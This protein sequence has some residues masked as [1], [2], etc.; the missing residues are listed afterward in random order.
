MAKGT[1]TNK[2]TNMPTLGAPLLLLATLWGAVGS[3]LSAFT[4]INDRRDKIIA[5]IEE[6]GRCSDKLL[7]PLELYLTN[8]LPLSLGVCLFLLIVA[9]IVVQIPSYMV[10]DDQAYLHRMKFAAWFI[11][12]LPAFC[13][14]GFLGGAIF[15]GWMVVS[16]LSSL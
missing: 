10:C 4:I 3:V 15:D 8:L 11:A 6:C 14:L 13:F 1:D 2:G 9:V 16:K 7:G 12:S 5:L